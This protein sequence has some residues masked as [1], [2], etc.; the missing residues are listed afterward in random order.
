MGD[1]IRRNAPHRAPPSCCG[2]P[3]SL[4]SRARPLHGMHPR[5]RALSSG[6]LVPAN[7]SPL[8]ASPALLPNAGPSAVEAPSPKLPDTPSGFIKDLQTPKGFSDQSS[9]AEQIAPTLLL[10]TFLR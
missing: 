6:G 5:L 4:R 3:N 8:R 10:H 7:P 2:I 9:L 1:H